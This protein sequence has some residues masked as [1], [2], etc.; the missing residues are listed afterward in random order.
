MSASHQISDISEF[1]NP[2]FDFSRLYEI[3]KPDPVYRNE[4]FITMEEFG[5]LSDDNPYVVKNRIITPFLICI[6]A[7]SRKHPRKLLRSVQ[8]QI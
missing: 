2:E 6:T 7:R 1:F 3:R 8:I 5:N 4:G